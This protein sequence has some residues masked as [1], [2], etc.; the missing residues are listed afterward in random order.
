M[1]EIWQ[2]PPMFSAIKVHYI[3]VY[4]EAMVSDPCLAICKLVITLS[5]HRSVELPAYFVF[6]KARGC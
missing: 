1:G 4:T 6:G 2:V 5:C 3:L